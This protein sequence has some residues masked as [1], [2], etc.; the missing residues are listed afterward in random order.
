MW[1]KDRMV[2]RAFKECFANLDAQQAAGEE[3]DL[4]SACVSETEALIKYTKS[5]IGNYKD[6]TFQELSEKK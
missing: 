3:V 6:N 5:I 1:E 2:L 4:S